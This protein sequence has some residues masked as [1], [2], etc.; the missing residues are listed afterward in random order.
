MD[1]KNRCRV[2]R[3]SLKY[4]VMKCHYLLT[5]IADILMQFYEKGRPGI[6]RAKGK[7]Q[8]SSV[9]WIV[10]NHPKLFIL[11]E[12]IQVKNSLIF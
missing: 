2:V 11:V 10:E 3:E 1:R 12:K 9:H 7:M 8:L 6:R 5:Q 4:N